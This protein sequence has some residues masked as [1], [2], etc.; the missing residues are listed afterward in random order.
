[1]KW[2]KN[3][4]TT[5]IKENDR[6]TKTEN[7]KNLKPTQKCLKLAEKLKNSSKNPNLR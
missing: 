6:G 3:A 2:N 5:Q 7:A 1:M 4:K